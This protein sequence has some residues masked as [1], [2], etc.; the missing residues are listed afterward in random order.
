MEGLEEVRTSSHLDMPGPLKPKLHDPSLIIKAETRET[1]F[2]LQSFEF[3]FFLIF[4]IKVYFSLKK[5]TLM[6]CNYAFEKGLYAFLVA[7]NV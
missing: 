2:C 3:F 4:S 1:G 6:F 7:K 5:L